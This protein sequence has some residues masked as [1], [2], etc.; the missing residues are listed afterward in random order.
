MTFSLAAARK[1]YLSELNNPNA[2]LLLLYCEGDVAGYSYAHVEQVDYLDTDQPECE[3]EVLYLQPSFRGK[4]LA[5]VLLSE[6][7]AW[8]KRKHAFRLRADILSGNESSINFFKKHG[9]LPN[10]ARYVLSL[11][12]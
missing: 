9:F 8:A 10:S 12:E 5:S 4:D 3:L 7:M 2:Q 11:D 1:R 6:V